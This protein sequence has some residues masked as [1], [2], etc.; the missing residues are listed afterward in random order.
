MKNYHNIEPSAFRRGE[1]VGYADGAWRIRK[2]NGQWLAMHSRSS[3]SFYVPTL[4]DV[5]IFLD[6]HITVPNRVTEHV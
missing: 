4:R 2:E 6:N 3:A 1:Y 5:S